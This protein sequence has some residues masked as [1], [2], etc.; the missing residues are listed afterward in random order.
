MHEER[1]I[2]LKMLEEGKISAD[3]AQELLGALEFSQVEETVE[4][5]TEDLS[6]EAPRSE[7]RQAS[8]K[9]RDG[10]ESG[11]PGV[12]IGSSVKGLEK[13]PD[14]LEGLLGGLGMFGSGHKFEDVVEGQ[15]G[16]GEDTRVEL[17]SV[18]GRLTVHGW[19][20][21]GYRAV[22]N[23]TIRATS[24]EQAEEKRKDA[25]E[26]HQEDN[27]LR[28]ASKRGIPGLGISVELHLPRD[29]VFDLDLKTSN[30]RVEVEGIQ[31]G[32][33]EAVTSNGRIVV[34]D[35]KVEKAHLS[36]SNGRIEALGVSGDLKANT[37]NGRVV[38]SAMPSEKDREMDIRTS[39]G[40]VVVGLADAADHGYKIR[41]STSI[42]KI[43]LTSPDME[44]LEGDTKSKEGARVLRNRLVARSRNIDQKKAVST[45]EVSTSNG[46]IRLGPEADLD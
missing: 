40:K 42:G 31:A 17:R 33:V 24:R 18:N 20:E 34:K 32:Q 5:P 29:R 46:T 37:S 1:M 10:E 11:F 27:L 9:K 26:V 35:S 43:I 16:P 22:I 23:T 39:N 19:D 36:T 44:I 21:P 12:D 25:F 28:I 45:I 13:L 8:P 41:A 4:L 15:L 7:E 14:L 6:E 2:I 30:G 3:E 38:V